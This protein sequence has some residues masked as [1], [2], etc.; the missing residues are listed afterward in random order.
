MVTGLACSYL[1]KFLH[2]FYDQLLNFFGENFRAS[3]NELVVDVLQTLQ[4]RLFLSVG[5][6]TEKTSCGSQ[7]I[8]L[9]IQKVVLDEIS[10]RYFG[11]FLLLK[12]LEVTD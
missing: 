4:A 11:I 5:N 8:V 12:V 7:W 9:K 1:K 10:K 6:L 2:F 3:F